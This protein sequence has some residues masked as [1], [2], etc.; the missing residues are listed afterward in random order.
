MGFVHFNGADALDKPLSL[1]L[2]FSVSG[3]ATNKNDLFFCVCEFERRSS[4]SLVLNVSEF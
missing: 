1:S 3:K 2:S 4:S